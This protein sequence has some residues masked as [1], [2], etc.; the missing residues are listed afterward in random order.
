MKTEPNQ[1]LEPTIMLVTI[2]AFLRFAQARI[3]PSMI[4]AHLER[5]ANRNP[6]I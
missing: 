4:A 6:G 3:A 1:A 5:S 2:R